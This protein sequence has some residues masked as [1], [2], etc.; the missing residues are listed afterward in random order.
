[1]STRV[2]PDLVDELCRYGAEDVQKCFNCGNCTAVCSLAE[3]HENFPRRSMRA[4]Q[5]GMQD[6]L[7]GSLEPWLCYYCGECSTYCPRGASPGETM[8]SLRRWLTSRYD[9]TGISRLFYLRPRVEVLAVIIVALLTGLGFTLFGMSTGSIQ[10]YTGPD[11][12]LPASAIHIFDWCLAAVLLAF[13]IPNMFRMWWFTI[14]R[15]TTGRSRSMRLSAG[16]YLKAV[17]QFPLHFFTQKRYSQCE[18]K[19]P[20]AVHLALMLSYVTML[21]LIM[22][23]LKYMWAGPAIDWRVHVF[24]YLASAGL[25]FATLWA[26]M[27]R[28]KKMDP[29]HEHS[30]ESDW[31]F[32][33]LLLVVALTGVLQ[34]VLHRANADVAAN[35]A[36]VVHLMAVVPMLGLEV[37]FSKWSHMAYRPLAMYFATLRK[38]MVP[39]P[40]PENVPGDMQTEPAA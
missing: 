2:N 25:I 32:L 11:A 6:K 39:A 38:R 36:Y 17:Y 21:V 10:N 31:I 22:F 9:F 27:S 30:H 1:M 5:L 14:G 37:P 20:W 19:R 29:Q 28:V 24:G 40:A 8:M 15:D 33:I 3:E 34:H 23:F 7:K 4:L 12:F 18:R 35:V 16:A 13:L 26:I